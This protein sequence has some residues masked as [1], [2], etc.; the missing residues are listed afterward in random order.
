M[1]YSFYNITAADENNQVALHFST[2][3]EVIVTIPDGFYTMAQFITV[4]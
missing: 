3:G 2:G 1:P 4:V